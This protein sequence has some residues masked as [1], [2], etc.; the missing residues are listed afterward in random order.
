MNFSEWFKKARKLG[1]YTLEEFAVLMREKGSSKV[2]YQQVHRWEKKKE[3]G[4]FEP[5]H[6]NLTLIYE[7]LGPPGTP[8]E[9][10]K[11]SEKGVETEDRKAVG[12]KTSETEAE[13]SVAKITVP[14]KEYNELVVGKADAEREVERLKEEIKRLSKETG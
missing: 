8:H 11:H 6:K 7:I 5:S 10:Q 14:L 1:G 13:A 4:G 2:T 9:E 12:Y 3:D